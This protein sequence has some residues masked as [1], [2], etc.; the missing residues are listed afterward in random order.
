MER[1]G[2]PLSRAVSGYFHYRKILADLEEEWVKDELAFTSEQCR[3][4]SRDLER[5]AIELRAQ[6]R[7]WEQRAT[8][9]MSK[10]GRNS[11]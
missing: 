3:S 6:A 1:D 9:T 4:I 7:D 8:D 11:V 5:R 10:E 2:S